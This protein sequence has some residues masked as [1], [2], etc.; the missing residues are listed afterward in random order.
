VCF[1]DEPVPPVLFK[2]SSEFHHN[3]FLHKPDESSQ[4]DRDEKSEF[5]PDMDPFERR[6]NSKEGQ[7]NHRQAFSG[8]K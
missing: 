4:S 2:A 1:A 5:P 7:Q 3:N 8:E 6:N